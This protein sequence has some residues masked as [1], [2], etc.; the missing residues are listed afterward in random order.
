MEKAIV[1]LGSCP[2]FDPNRVRAIIGEAVQTCF[3]RLKIHGRV[4][5]KP[6][7][8]LAHPR[9]TSHP[10]THPKVVEGVLNVIQEAGQ[11]IKS[12]DIVEKSGL[13]VTT[14]GMYRWAG[15]RRLRKRYPVRLRAMEERPKARVVLRHGIVHPYITVAREMVLNDFLIFMPVLKTNVLSDAYSGALKLNIGSIDSRERMFHHHRDLPLKIVDILEGINPNLIV[16]DGVRLSYGGNQMTQHEISFGCIAVSTNAV[17]HDM[18]CARMIGLDPF[19]IDHIRQA[20]ERG[21]GPAS[22]DQIEIRGDFSIEEG[23]KKVD[24]LDFGYYSV[25]QFDSPLRIHTGIP[26]CKGGC[27]GI[28]LD[29]L[30]MIRDRKPKLLKRFPKIPVLIG[31]VDQKIRS[32]TVL[33]VG[34]C[35]E[36]S[37]DIR[38]RRV[39]RIR[40]CPPSHKRIV[41]DMMVN[42]FLLAPLVRPSLIIDG[43]VLYPIKKVKG[44][45]MNAFYRPMIFSES[46]NGPGE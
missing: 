23:L 16:T 13:G 46:N 14:A 39:V 44:W 20:I 12:V 31:R 27:H 37:S 38:A 24:G 25:D 43:F 9:V 15:Y 19:G 36:A 17:A 2:S 21:Y 1:Y 35:A 30:H 3:P 11:Q 45:L 7:L 29:W 22:F 28:F 5:I 32:K 26:Y 41:W 42:F 18:V 6:N 4:V 40:G 10:Y 8:V 33:L 34:H